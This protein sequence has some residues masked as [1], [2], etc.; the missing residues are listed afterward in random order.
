MRFLGVGVSS[1]VEGG[2]LPQLELFQEEGPKESERHRTISR[3]VDDL[4][5]RFGDNAV[6]P[7]GMLPE[8]DN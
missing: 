4:K 3:V 8:G 7:G 2:G 5:D 1:L 6:L